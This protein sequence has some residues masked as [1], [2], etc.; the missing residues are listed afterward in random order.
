MTA[1]STTDTTITTSTTSQKV[2]I[3]EP[4]VSLASK[5]RWASATLVMGKTSAIIGLT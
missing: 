3:T 1:G 2:K 4:V 5:A